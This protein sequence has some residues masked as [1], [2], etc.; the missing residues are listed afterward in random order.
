ME[1]EKRKGKKNN[2]GIGKASKTPRIPCSPYRLGDALKT[3][4]NRN[5]SHSEARE[6]TKCTMKNAN[7]E[8]TFQDKDL[9][10]LGASIVRQQSR[11]S[12]GNAKIASFPHNS[13]LAIHPRSLRQ[14]NR[15]CLS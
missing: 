9:I 15:H 13:R 5:Y 6:N 11:K 8:S 1:K 12:H 2:A 3:L 4:A 7:D 14:A 10:N